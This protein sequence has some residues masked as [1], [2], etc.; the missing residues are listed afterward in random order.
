[1]GPMR[2]SPRGGHG[3]A[4]RGLTDFLV[5]GDCTL[6][7]VIAPDHRPRRGGDAPARIR[8]GPGGQGANVAVRLAR[9][10][11][12]VRL[13]AAMADDPPGRLLRQA[14][15][16][17][18]VSLLP[19]PARRTALVAVLLDPAGERTMLSDRQPLAGA[20]PPAAI[21][22]A[23]WVH[24]SGYALLDDTTGDALA[25]AFGARPHAVRLSVGG[26]SLPP[27]RAPVARFRERLRTATPQLCLFSQDEA[28]ALLGQPASAPEAAAR[29][30]ELADVMVVTAG[31]HGAVAAVGR[32]LVAAPAIELTGPVVDA[33]GA[34]DAYAALLIARLAA[35]R[36]P[37]T[38]A[39]LHR[40]MIAAGRLGS[41][42][43]RVAGAQ[44][45]VAGERRPEA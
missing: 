41:R 20:P 4:P 22:G 12:G 8:L 3:E 30:A 10:S 5:V 24:C 15:K 28:S 11:H 6:D 23:G 19:M 40:A 18:R 43:A 44:G 37:P 31:P 34:G 35:A 38:P 21:A 33:T 1:M 25:A 16:R 9:L 36:W 26:G 45:W 32:R 14:L 17:E 39:G 27:Q 7:V 42:V 29:L 13:L 2:A